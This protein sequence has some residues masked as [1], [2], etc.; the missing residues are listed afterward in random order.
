[1]ELAYRRRAK[2]GR[3]RKSSKRRTPPARISPT[4][5][6]GVPVSL[7]HCAD[8]RNTFETKKRPAYRLQVAL[9]FRRTAAEPAVL[10]GLEVGGAPKEGRCADR[11]RAQHGLPRAASH[12]RPHDAG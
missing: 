9:G 10:P 7:F 5:C 2:G 12:R 8:S 4:K 11:V 6:H 1:M 3:F